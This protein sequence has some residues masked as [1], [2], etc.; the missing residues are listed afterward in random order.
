L[1][2]SL[3]D[4]GELVYRALR[5][6]K[7]SCSNFIEIL[8]VAIESQKPIEDHDNTITTRGALE[9]E[10]A[11][12]IATLK[13]ILKKNKPPRNLLRIPLLYNFLE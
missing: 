2:V 3:H 8:V 6:D 4:K 13:M 10:Y 1:I 5:K 7:I 12:E 11:D 9:C